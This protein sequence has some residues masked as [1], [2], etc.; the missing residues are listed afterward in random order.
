[1][2]IDGLVGA[3]YSI[4]SLNVSIVNTWVYVAM[5]RKDNILYLFVNGLL[6]GTI[7]LPSSG[8]IGNYSP[9]VRIG[10]TGGNPNVQ[11]SFD[12]YVDEIRITKGIARYTSNFI[13]PTKPFPN[14]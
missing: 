13:P 14:K 7:N 4:Q 6:Q 1:M 3:R 11:Y 10:R 9:N 2:F 12:G 8:D 5:V